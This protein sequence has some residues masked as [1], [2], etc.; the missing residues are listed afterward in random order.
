MAEKN[1]AALL[2]ESAHTVGVQFTTDADAQVYTYITNINLEVGDIVVVPTKV[3]PTRTGEIRHMIEA[4]G[5]AIAVK[6]AVVATVDKM[7]DIPANDDKE[8]A[9]VMDRVQTQYYNNKMARNLQIE[10]AVAAAYQKTLRKSFA[11]RILGE[12]AN[13][14]RAELMKL[15]GK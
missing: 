11:E 10:R 3:V 9:W 12:L 15:L 4:T 5:K 14:D 7:V 1:I 8:Y 13:D 6:L 2:D